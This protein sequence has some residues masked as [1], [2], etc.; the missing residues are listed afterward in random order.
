MPLQ[1]VG[2]SPRR[3]CPEHSRMGRND[4][5]FLV[6]I[7]GEESRSKE[8]QLFNLTTGVEALAGR[9]DKL[10]KSDSLCGNQGFLGGPRN[11][12]HLSRY[13]AQV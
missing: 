7:F 1:I 2:I 10:F 4:R 5:S 6:A 12:N 9:M 13:L 3:V 11:D 8:W